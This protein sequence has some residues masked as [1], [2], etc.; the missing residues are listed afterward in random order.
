MFKN[1]FAGLGI[2]LSKRFVIWLLGGLPNFENKEEV[3]LWCL[4]NHRWIALLAQKT[5]NTVDDRFADLLKAVFE[6]PALFDLLW[7]RAASYE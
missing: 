4:K 6:S 7:E 3:R 2:D 1:L 5:T